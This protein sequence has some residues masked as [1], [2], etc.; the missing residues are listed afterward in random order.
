MNTC[1]HTSFPTCSMTFSKIYLEYRE[2]IRAYIAYRIPNKYEAEDLTQ[3]V[4]MHLLDYG[5]LIRNETIVSFLFT[6]AR[7]LVTDNLRRYYK[8][9][10]VMLEWE[11]RTA[12]SA[13]TTEQDIYANELASI[14]K[15]QIQNLPQQRRKVYELIDCHD[16]S[17]PEV[18]IRM[19]LS[20]HT[21]QNHL[22]IAR[23]EIKAQLSYLLEAV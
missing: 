21:I 6:I 13:C 17:I 19:K 9:K 8:Y 5:K 18:A 16:L 14:Y 3:D 7:N 20:Q 1:N 12:T 15:K 23:K 2:V 10:E 11:I 22:Y 4:F